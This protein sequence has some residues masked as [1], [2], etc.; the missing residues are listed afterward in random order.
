MK[1]REFDAFWR[2]EAIRF[3]GCQFCLAVESLDDACRDNAQG[4]ERVKDQL[5]VPQI[6]G[7]FLHRPKPAAHGLSAP[8]LEELARSC[9]ADVFPEPLELLTEQMGPDALEV[10]LHKFGEFSGMVVRAVAHDFRTTGR[11]FTPQQPRRDRLRTDLATC[12]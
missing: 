4:E 3:S 5:P 11:C 2:A 1:Q 8:R 12:G 7:D 10:V 6:L 9:R